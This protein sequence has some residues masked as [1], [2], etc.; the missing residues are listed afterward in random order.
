MTSEYIRGEAN[1]VTE[2]YED[3]IINSIGMEYKKN[4]VDL[5]NDKQWSI[6]S[7]LTVEELSGIGENYE[8]INNTPYFGSRSGARRIIE[9]RSD[10]W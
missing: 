5:S 7:E 3:P 4:N 8:P 6:L 1:K 2:V 9:W 10:L